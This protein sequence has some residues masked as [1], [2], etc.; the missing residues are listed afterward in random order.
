MTVGGSVCLGKKKPEKHFFFF[1]AFSCTH[2]KALSLP[3]FVNPHIFFGRMVADRVIHWAFM[4]LL[5]GLSIVP[6]LTTACLFPS[7]EHSTTQHNTIFD[8]QWFP[9]YLINLSRCL[10][11]L[12]SISN[13]LSD[14]KLSKRIDLSPTYDLV[15]LKTP[16]GLRALHASKFQWLCRSKEILNQSRW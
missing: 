14:V 2:H 3:V 5:G 4:L 1:F 15:E 12:R 13:G 11:L 7:W 10:A 8:P 16:Y 9:K 6:L